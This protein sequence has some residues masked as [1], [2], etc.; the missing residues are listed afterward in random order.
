MAAFQ[1]EY[2]YHYFDRARGPFRSLTALPFEEAKA[3]LQELRYNDLKATNPNINWFL[4]RRYA[5]EK[6]AR[7]Q[8]IALGGRPVRSAPVYCTLGPNENM[9]TWFHNADF[10]KMPVGEFDL[11]TVSFTYGDMFAVFNPK[12]NT[13]EEWWGKVYRYEEIVALAE[14]YGLPEDPVYDMKN[15]VF[16]KGKPINQYLKYIEAQVWSDEALERYKT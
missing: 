10:I 1:L 11:N 13:G 6:T 4:T 14:K 7:D 8:F 5:D 2:L 16:P 9:K 12:L 15:W 3:V